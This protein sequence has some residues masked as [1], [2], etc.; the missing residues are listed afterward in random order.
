MIEIVIGIVGLWI[1]IKTYQKSFS[2][3]L[4]EPKE[5]KDNLLA[6]Y[7]MTQRLSLEVQQQIL[8]YIEKGYG[9]KEMYPNIT[10]KQFLI[11]AK[12]EFDKSLSDK[13]YNDLRDL[14]MTKSNIASMLNMIET[15]NESLT[16]LR[17]QMI[18]LNHN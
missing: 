18:L 12:D 10:F 17:N 6:N 3:K 15:Q 16:E 4:P 13:L 2:S 7:K 5:E 14:P 1:A 8:S 11:I 9:D